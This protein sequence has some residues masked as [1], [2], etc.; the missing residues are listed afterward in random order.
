MKNQ[1]IRPIFGD[2]N[3]VIKALDGSRCIYEADDFFVSTNLGFVDL[4][5]TGIATPEISVQ[6][7]ETISKGRFRDFFAAI[8]GNYNQKWLSQ[9][10]LVELCRTRPDLLG[11]K[12]QKTL[13]VIKKDE[14]KAINEHNPGNNLIV[15]SVLVAPGG[16]RVCDFSFDDDIIWEFSRQ[17]ISPKVQSIAY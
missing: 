2:R 16:L 8:P 10:Q 9:N 14:H 5:G 11:R 12:G 13:F 15:V 17:I 1:I 7:N 4:L 3:I 6:V